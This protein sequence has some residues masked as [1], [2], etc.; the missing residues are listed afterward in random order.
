M[1]KNKSK[2]KLWD[3]P[4]G[5]RESFLIAVFMLLTGFVI[6]LFTGGGVSMP[7]WPVNIAIILVF[8]IYF[9]LVHHFIKHPLVTWLSSVPAAIAS[10]SVFTLMVLFMGFIPQGSHQEADLLEKLGLRQITSSWPYLFTAVFL[11]VVLG[12]TIVR[13]FNSYSLKNIAFLLN[14]TGLWIVVVAASLGSSDMWR[15]SMQ[16]ETKHPVTTAYDA[17]GQAYNM[18]FGMLLLDFNIE[19]YDPQVGLMRNADYTLQLEKGGKLATVIEGETG[20]LEN[21]ELTFQRYIDNAHKYGEVYDTS[22]MPGGSHAV[23]II[24]KDQNTGQTV[25]GWVSDGSIDTSPSFLR[26]NSELSIAMTNVRPKKFSSDIRVYTSMEEFE[27]FRIEVNKPVNVQGWKIY[28]TGYDEIMGRWSNKSIIEL[29]RD[30]W[31]PA[32]YTGIFMILIGTLY[33]LWMGKGRTKKKE[34]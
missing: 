26:L 27:D 10:I 8:I 29:V 25:E 12:F 11:L 33:L 14:H 18:G 15:L 3:F 32:V 20:I 16:L 5:Y 22:S 23:Y 6:E 19:E 34:L 17:R 9:I 21:Y 28:Q 2:T 7:T 30:P 24:A 13:R 4:W 1:A 31:L